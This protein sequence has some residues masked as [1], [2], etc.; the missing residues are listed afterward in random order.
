M[1]RIRKIHKNI[2]A[3]P[4]HRVTMNIDRDKLQRA[5][6][7]LGTKTDTDA[8]DRALDLVLANQETQGAIDQIFGQAPDFSIS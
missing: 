1:A 3:Q 6:K 4:R 8:V 7:A 5:R 2:S